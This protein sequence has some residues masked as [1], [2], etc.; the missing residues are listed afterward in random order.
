MKVYDDFTLPVLIAKILC[1]EPVVITSLIA[2][3]ANIALFTKPL[4][5]LKSRS[6]I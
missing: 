3:H 2:Y 1:D 6:L 4:K 5:L